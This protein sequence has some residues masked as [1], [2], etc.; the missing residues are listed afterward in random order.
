MA[1]GIG[2][3]N[4]V[5]VGRIE[6]VVDHTSSVDVVRN[7]RDIAVSRKDVLRN[8]LVGAGDQSGDVL[9]D[10]IVKDGAVE[11]H[12]ENIR[13]N[14]VGLLQR[15]P[16]QLT[17]SGHANVVVMN[18]LELH[19]PG[20]LNAGLV[21]VDCVGQ[22]RPGDEPQGCVLVGHRCN[23]ADAVSVDVVGL[24]DGRRSVSHADVA[25]GN[26]VVM[27]SALK[28]FIDHQSLDLI[29]ADLARRDRFNVDRAGLVVFDN[30]IG[31]ATR[32]DRERRFNRV[33]TNQGPRCCPRQRK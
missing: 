33:V 30:D 7:D 32:L 28:G 3:S 1:G 22:R 26:C 23:D 4:P 20:K 11:I 9:G 14:R 10:P 12:T 16:A 15:C 13:V 17:D 19:P 8:L 31:A 21:V 6:R 29:L 5:S 27:D 18:G 2:C 24:Q 25:S